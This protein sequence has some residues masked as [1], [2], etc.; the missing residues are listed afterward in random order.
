MFIWKTNGYIAKCYFVLFK[1]VFFRY[2]NLLKGKEVR[3]SKTL[4]GWKLIAERRQK[5]FY[6]VETPRSS[7]PTFS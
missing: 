3:T 6:G 7:H 1:W 2:I 5:P 4:T